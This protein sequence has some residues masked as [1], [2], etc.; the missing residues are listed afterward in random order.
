[1]LK[2]SSGGP[3]IRGSVLAIIGRWPSVASVFAHRPLAPFDRT[4]RPLGARAAGE[5]VASPPGVASLIA[6]AV[7]ASKQAGSLA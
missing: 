1:M 2:K 5:N 6:G 7:S 3:G 4:A